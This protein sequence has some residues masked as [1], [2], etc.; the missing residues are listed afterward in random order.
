MNELSPNAGLSF[1]FVCSCQL[2]FI[3]L[4]L[5]TLAAIV[6]AVFHRPSVERVLAVFIDD[7]FVCCVCACFNPPDVPEG[8]T[9]RQPCANTGEA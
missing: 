2:H 5:L 8:E 9:H 4:T 7:P 3:C 6:S 1:S